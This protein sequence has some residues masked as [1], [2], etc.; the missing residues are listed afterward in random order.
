MEGRRQ[1]VALTGAFAGRQG[2]DGLFVYT[3]SSSAERI[4]GWRGPPV[5]FEGV[6]DPMQQLA[7][8]P[9]YELPRLE[10]ELPRVDGA[11]PRP[12][13]QPA[14]GGASSRRPMAAVASSP[15]PAPPVRDHAALRPFSALCLSMPGLNFACQTSSACERLIVEVAK[16]LEPDAAKAA[17]A[18]R[19]LR[20]RLSKSGWN[21]FLGSFRALFGDNAESRLLGD[22]LK[23][24]N[25]LE[26]RKTMMD[27]GK[28][29]RRHTPVGSGMLECGCKLVIGA[30]L[31]GPGMHWRFY[32]GLHIAA[33]CAALRSHLLISA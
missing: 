23:A 27:Y 33:L 7:A 20:R 18:S 2:W 14:G 15:I 9:G 17:K 24:W 31:K 22:S 4:F 25:Y 19:R 3:W 12:G 30:R 21:A 16:A 29:R 13:A 28:L 10:T 11:L 32:N 6:A 1:G 5:F 8:P 26:S